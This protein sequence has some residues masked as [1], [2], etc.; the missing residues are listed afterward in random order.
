MTL[1]IIGGTGFDQLESMEK[2][3]THKV[4][5]VWGSPSDCI[6]EGLLG[7]KKI[8]FLRRHGGET[9]YPPHKINY[10]ANI[11]ALEIL[12]ATSVI[13]TAA[14]GGIDIDLGRILVPDQLIDYTHS[15]ESTFFEGGLEPLEHIDFTHPYDTEL[16]KKIIRA[17]SS[18][19]IKV[20]TSGTYGVTQGPRLETASEI[21]RLKK[22]GC[23]I[24]GMT[25]MP[26]AALAKEKGMPYATVS[27]VVNPAAGLANKELLLSDMLSVLSEGGKTFVKILEAIEY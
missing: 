5:T 14:V 6:Y 15:R 11:A 3:R 23:N 21:Q 4:N 24:V 17:A 19:S 10:R 9:K 18:K 26:E 7:S 2:I 1:A 20:I 16:R 22:D 12:G 8:F 25:G 27:I 13:G